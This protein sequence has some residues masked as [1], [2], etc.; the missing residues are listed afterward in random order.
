[1]AHVETRDGLRPAKGGGVAERRRGGP[2]SFSRRK[3]SR[4]GEK[5]KLARRHLRTQWVEG[6]TLWPCYPIG[7]GKESHVGEKSQL[8]PSRKNYRR[9]EPG[10][11]EGKS[12]RSAAGNAEPWGRDDV[13]KT[14]S[15]LEG[16]QKKSELFQVSR[17]CKKS[18][19]QEKPGALRTNNDT[20]CLGCQGRGTCAG[21]E[22][23]KVCS[24]LV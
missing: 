18:R 14:F 23:F 5:E 7:E 12:P 16:Y 2:P 24:M 6:A 8:A 22:G 9:V 20:V 11:G 19:N 10:E 1:M 15:E 3:K 4:Q 21:G 13:A 17:E